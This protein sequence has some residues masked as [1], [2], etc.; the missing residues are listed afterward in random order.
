MDEELVDLRTNH[1][2]EG[3]ID[4]GSAEPTLSEA[5]VAITRARAK[6]IEQETKD[7]LIILTQATKASIEDDRHSKVV[8]SRR[9]REPSESTPTAPGDLPPSL[10]DDSTPLS[11]GDSSAP[12]IWELCGGFPLAIDTKLYRVLIS[13]D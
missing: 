1:F 10:P 13:L 11:P 9:P 2:Q 12:S 5:E 6:R 3:E 8:A 4:E 7:L